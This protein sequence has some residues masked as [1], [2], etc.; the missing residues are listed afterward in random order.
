MMLVMLVISNGWGI[1]FDGLGI[2]GL[3][4]D[5]GR[6]GKIVL[7]S[8]VFR[9]VVL[10]FVVLVRLRDFGSRKFVDNRS[11]GGRRFEMFMLVRGR[12]V[13]RLSGIDQQRIVRGA[14]MGRFV[15]IGRGGR[16][17]L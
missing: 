5:R 4:R 16:L 7:R 10:V 3:R 15:Q 14:G 6:Q 11:G 12:R 17:G 2:N 1:N 13:A 9:P 8:A